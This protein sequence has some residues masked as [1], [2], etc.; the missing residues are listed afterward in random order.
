MIE[1]WN[2]RSEILLRSNKE[3]Q[4]WIFTNDRSNEFHIILKFLNEFL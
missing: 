3:F 1:V 2:F 4:V